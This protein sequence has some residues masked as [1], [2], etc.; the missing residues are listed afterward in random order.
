MPR[1]HKK[2]ASKR[3]VHSEDALDYNKRHLSIDGLEKQWNGHI[4]PRKDEY[5]FSMNKIGVTNSL[6]D[7]ILERNILFTC[8]Y[9]DTSEATEET[10]ETL[11]AIVVY[12]LESP[13][14]LPQ[15]KDYYK[16]Y[17]A[18][19]WR[20]GKECIRLECESLSH[21]EIAKRLKCTQANVSSKLAG[22]N[23]KKKHPTPSIYERIYTVL[24]QRPEVRKLL[25][26][27]R[28]GGQQDE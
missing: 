4:G 10:L 16:S 2:F 23:L 15:L 7:R 12:F 19:S 8:N 13:D 26:Q 24:S 25:K 11:I 17:T 28:E 27:L 6:L 22:C 14:S 21:R 18:Y 3:Y 5:I 1:P 20:I 9:N